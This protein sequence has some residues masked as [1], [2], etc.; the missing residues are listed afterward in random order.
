MLVLE[1]NG[2][3][4]VEAF[5]ES[6]I[7]DFD[8]YDFERE[9]KRPHGTAVKVAFSLAFAR[10]AA[11]PDAGF[12]TCQQHFPENFWNP[13]FQKHTNSVSRVA[14]VV[15]V[16]D[17]P[18]RHRDFM[19]AFTGAAKAVNTDAGFV[20]A[21]PRGVIDVTTPPAFLK[22]YGVPAP[23]ASRGARLAAL[24][25]AAADASLLQSVPEL[26]G[27]GGLYAG[28][29]TVIG[30]DDAMGAVLIFEPSR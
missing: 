12:F 16:A 15:M 21:T 9:G 7:G 17:E 19:L 4:D 3:A 24:R 8:L 18:A 11:A 13:A 26:A 1:G 2:A 6:G 22:R 27:I 23:G 28:N 25:F 14:G 10:D 29:P 5:R 20:I 30:P